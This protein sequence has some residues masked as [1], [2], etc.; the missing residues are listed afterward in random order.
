MPAHIVSDCATTINTE[1]VSSRYISSH[2][3]IQIM[4]E[5][6]IQ[7]ET[8]LYLAM[9]LQIPVLYLLAETFL[10]I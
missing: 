6:F 8:T 4:E 7:A 9:M 10:F 1:Q 5:P 3:H 2:L